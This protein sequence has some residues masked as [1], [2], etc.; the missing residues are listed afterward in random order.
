MDVQ[1]FRYW[2]RTGARRATV[3]ATG[4]AAN[5]DGPRRGRVHGTRVDPDASER[6]PDNGPSCS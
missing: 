3:E 2:A 4:L 6:R 5:P 1:A